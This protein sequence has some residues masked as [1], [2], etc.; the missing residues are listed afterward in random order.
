MPKI[1]I[2]GIEYNTEDMTDNAKAQVASL[3]F[4]EAQM[5][6][7]KSEI[8]V[9][10]TAKVAYISALKTEL[11]KWSPQN[12]NILSEQRYASSRMFDRRGCRSQL[13]NG[14][15]ILTRIDTRVHKLA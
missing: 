7:I 5:A 12:D 9:Y 4:L 6:K 14:T 13:Q 11:D 1:S 10:E 8:A 15:Q 3:Q 2:D